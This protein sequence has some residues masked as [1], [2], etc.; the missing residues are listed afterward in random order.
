MKNIV[1]L[2]FFL[3]F[4]YQVIGQI[5]SSGHISK[6]RSEIEDHNPNDYVLEITKSHISIAGDLKKSNTILT[7]SVFGYLPYWEYPD[8]LDYLQYDLLSHIALFDFEVNPDGSIDYPPNWPWTDLIT[9]AHQ[10]DVKLILTAVNFNGSQIHTILTNESVKSAFFTNILLAIQQYNLDGVNIDFEEIN[11]SD[12]G[13]VLNNFMADLSSFIHTSNSNYEVSFA[14][15]PINWGSWDFEGLA[16]SCDYLF[17]MGY[18]FYGPWSNT[19]GP[20]APTTGGT[21]NITNVIIDQYWDVVEEN[22]HKLILGVPYY[23]NKWKTYTSEPYS[24]VIN[25]ISQPRYSTAINTAQQDTI[26]WDGISSTSWSYHESSDYYHQTWFDNDSSLGFKYSLV[27]DYQLKG[28][29]MWAL[30]YD[31]SRMELW[32]LLRYYFGNSVSIEDHANDFIVVYPN[33]ATNKIKFSGLSGSHNT[34]Q[35]F[36][37]VGNLVITEMLSGNETSINIDYLVDGMYFIIISPSDE[38]QRIIKQIVKK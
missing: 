11:S 14:S 25:H 10:N 21:Y 8:A 29:G 23:G 13:E 35:I 22:P 24:T 34:I 33:P 5:E 20:C 28:T 3:F 18:N 27:V 17:I 19:S 6:H 1:I 2:A 38:N 4:T 15:P 30:G 31:E 32:D 9:S 16:N 26:I 37:L 7:H 12:R 36:D